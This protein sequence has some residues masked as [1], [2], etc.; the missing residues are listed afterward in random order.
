MEIKNEFDLNLNKLL[1]IKNYCFENHKKEK[2][3]YI[4][5]NKS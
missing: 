2:Y 5:K 4:P 3:K 1:K